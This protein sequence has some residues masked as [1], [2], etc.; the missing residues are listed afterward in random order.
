MDAST[1]YDAIPLED[2]V[3]TLGP[4]EHGMM[5]EF[6]YAFNTV[7]TLQ[8]FGDEAACRTA[9]AEA[10]SACR[11]YERRFSRTLPHSDIARLNAAQGE[12]V[13][14]TTDTAQ[15]LQ[16][17]LRFCA[18]SEGRFDIT[19]GAVVQ[20]WD[21]RKGIIPTPGNINVALSHVDWRALRIKDEAARSS[22]AQSAQKHGTRDKGGART[23]YHGA[24]RSQAFAQLADPAAVL[25]VGGIAKGWIADRLDETIAAHALDAFVVNLGGN[26]VVRGEKPDGTSW[27]IGLQDPR[28]KGGIVG[29]IAVRNASAVTSGVYERCFKQGDTLYHHILDPKT[30]YPAQTDAAGAT[31]LT[32]HSVDAEGYSTTLLALGIEQGIAF[33]QKHPVILGAY[34]VDHNG[35]VHEA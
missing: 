31:V 13:A 24:E 2:S 19:M 21:F 28:D 10:R 18:D 4:D 1:T 34:F 26:V 30:G 12:P 17:A 23:A 25:D 8:A 35:D 11:R 3:T 16:A 22:A 32:R 20:L 5:T 9:F 6:F 33:A 15:L 7:V 27:R 29:A 14:I